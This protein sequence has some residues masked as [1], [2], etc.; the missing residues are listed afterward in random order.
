MPL[1]VYYEDLKTA[2]SQF[3]SPIRHA[4]TAIF[5]TFTY[6]ID[7]YYT[8]TIFALGS[9]LY[10]NYKQEEIILPLFI[11]FPLL[12]LFLFRFRL[13]IDPIFLL[14]EELPIIFLMEYV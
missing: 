7:A 13:L 2:H 14:P 1:H 10:N 6:V 12:F 8:V 5:F 3:L 4:I 9:F 11:S